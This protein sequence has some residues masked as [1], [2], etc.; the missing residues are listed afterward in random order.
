MNI[1]KTHKQKLCETQT[2]YTYVSNVLIILLRKKHT[3]KL[4]VFHSLL[5]KSM[6]T[7]IAALLYFRGV[8]R[9]SN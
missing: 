5:I 6:M 3:T 7:T 4:G 2:H 9:T 1:C 8:R